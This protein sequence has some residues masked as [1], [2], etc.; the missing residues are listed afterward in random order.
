M[1]VKPQITQANKILHKKEW[2]KNKKIV[3]STFIVSEE[4]RKRRIVFKASKK[5]EKLEILSYKK[6]YIKIIHL[7]FHQYPLNLMIKLV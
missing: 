7:C 3:V 5:K 2:L 1:L 6:T 4:A